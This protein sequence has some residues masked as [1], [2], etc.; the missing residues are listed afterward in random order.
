MNRLVATTERAF[1]KATVELE[2]SLSTQAVAG[3][4]VSRVES[5]R[6]EVESGR[7]V[8]R[9]SRVGGELKGADEESRAGCWVRLG[10]AFF[11][12]PRSKKCALNSR[13]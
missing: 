4:R 5:E 3:S 9:E 13:F 7:A 6:V 1:P 10:V 11:C 12:A 8:S 2:A